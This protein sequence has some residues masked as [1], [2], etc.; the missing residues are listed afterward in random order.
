M[1]GNVT[2]DPWAFARAVRNPEIKEVRDTRSG[3]IHDARR[4]IQGR[5]Y[6]RLVQVRN[7]IIDAMKSGKSRVVCA[8]CQVPAY[9][10]A[11]T[12]KTFFFRH[13]VENGSCPARTRS[14]LSEAE[15]RAMKYHGCRES[16]AHKQMKKLI[17]RSL[18]ADCRVSGVYKE[19]RWTSRYHKKRFRQP[20]V[21]AMFDGQRVAFEAQLTTTFLDVVAGRRTFYKD[22]GAVLIWVLRRFDPK[23]RR[24]TED[25][26]LFTNNFNVLVV[27]EE[28]AAISEATQ[29]CT[30]RCTYFEPVLNGLVLDKKWETRL[31]G[32]DE[33]KLDVE[34]QRAYWFDYEGAYA[35]LLHEQREAT[36]AQLRTDVLDF[37][38]AN[39]GRDIDN[40]DENVAWLSLKRRLAEFGVRVP[41]HHKTNRNFKSAVSSLLSAK[42][43][44]PVGF[45]YKKLIEVA[46][47]LAEQQKGTLWLFGWALRIY[48]TR[49]LI[50]KQDRS[51]RW[52]KKERR[53]RKSMASGDP[54][55]RPDET[56]SEAL[57]F[58]FP[59][60][61]DK[62]DHPL[63]Q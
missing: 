52:A 24:L 5:R 45:Q 11:R 19:K 44:R 55:Y 53:I 63:Y 56:W 23:Y 6:G 16:E 57:K 38:E 34:R 1:R 61:A 50:E 20:D 62:F 40:P 28:T 29:K 32:L 47:Y 21:Q 33:L 3:L 8:I 18:E 30:F 14:S 31:I 49:A 37:W 9:L 4:F 12:D 17:T 42:L 51:G 54:E 27:D 46:H 36:A 25:D 43:G 48:G 39:A 22:Q 58:L 10:V 7:I 26:I 60:I 41:E 2:I 59:E 13:K 35:D 15:I